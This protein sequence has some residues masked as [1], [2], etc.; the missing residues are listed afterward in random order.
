MGAGAP[1]KALRFA[2]I[3]IVA[4]VLG[5][6]LGYAIGVFLMDTVGAWLL[7]IYDP[8]GHVWEKIEEWYDANGMF[9]LLLAAIT[10][11]PFKVFTIASGA[12]SFPLVDFV[13]AC[14][15]GRGLRFGAEGLVLRIWG[16]PVVV[17]MDKWFD[18]AALGFSVL[19][20]GGFVALKYL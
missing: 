18:L 6:I 16:K 1:R 4:S 8:D 3:T 13:G 17:W 12:L 15:V 20:I 7:G 2:L 5:A 19:L 10:P 11:I 14:V 9:G